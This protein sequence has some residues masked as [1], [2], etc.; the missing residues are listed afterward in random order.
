MRKNQ[1][2]VVR[3]PIRGKSPKGARFEGAAVSRAHQAS[4]ER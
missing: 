3:I 4:G 1:N 2:P